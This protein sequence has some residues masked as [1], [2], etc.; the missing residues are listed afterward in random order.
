MNAINQS[1]AVGLGNAT[2][3]RGGLSASTPVLFLPV[4]IETRFMNS[5]TGAPELWVRIYPDQIAINSHE[6]ELTQQEITDGTAYW[7][8]V[9][10]AGTATPP[11]D[12]V[13]APWR[14]L[15]QRYGSPRAAW[16]ALQM[17]PSN[18]GLQP[19]APTPDGGTPNPLP[20][21]PT[22]P[23]RDASWTK[24]AI[25]EALPAFWTVV[26]VM[27]AQT[28][29]F[30]GGA[31]TPQ[32]A[33]SL[34][35]PATAF[36][37]GSPV[38]QRMQWLVDFDAALAAGMAVKV[39]LTVQQRA[40]GF[41]RIFVYGLCSETS[42]DGN[43][44]N[45]ATAIGSATLAALLN[46]HHYSDG[47]SLVPQGAPTN[48]TS[49]ASSFYSRKDPDF[50]IGF[51]VERQG[52]LNS[53]PADDGNLFAAALGIDPATMAHVRASDG[54]GARNGRDMLT[55]L[56]PAT[57]G[58]FLTQM[59]SSVFTPAQIETARQYVLANAIPRGPLPVM[60]SARHRTVCCRLPR[61]GAIPPRPRVR[62]ARSS[63]SWCNS[64]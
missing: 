59:M 31:I 25:T 57:L 10:R 41:D 46:D 7:D 2:A 43:A 13:K 21:Y 12:A 51:A 47:F 58:Y 40:Q 63:Q 3:A 24:P 4:N 33:V 62:Q 36:P 6:P 17:T 64:F 42:N 34:T 30:R 9:W 29:S 5:A 35:P 56:W 61:C 39:P 55:A 44:N 37:P 49:D 26:T 1:A 18:V 20:I 48:N 11:T 38:D 54:F 14:G 53:D 8:A 16:I 23:T 28:A 32:L 22:P 45:P 27:E 60:A 50:E 15:A 52:P 19:A